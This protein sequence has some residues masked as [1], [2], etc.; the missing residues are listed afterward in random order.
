MNKINKYI[1]NKFF[2]KTDDVITKE[3]WF[4]EDF[5][6][7]MEK[8]IKPKKKSEDSEI[9]KPK[10]KSAYIMFCI[11]ERN[12]MVDKN[13]NSDGKDIICLL[14]KQ[15]QKIKN[16]NP[17]IVEKYEKMAEE[18]YNS[19]MSIYNKQTDNTVSTFIENEKKCTKTTKCKKATKNK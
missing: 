19:Q 3:Q 12:N 6:N 10:K 18:D 1:S 2:S 8:L 17:E 13:K 7:K 4:A 5:Q 9:K 16:N 14:A 11:N 15:W